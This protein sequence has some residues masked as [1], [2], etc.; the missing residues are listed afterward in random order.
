MPS[1]ALGAWQIRKPRMLIAACRRQL[2]LAQLVPRL[3]LLGADSSSASSQTYRHL[4]SMVTTAEVEKVAAKPAW[5][6][7]IDNISPNLVTAQYAGKGIME[8]LMRFMYICMHLA[9]HAKVSLRA[10]NTS[11]AVDS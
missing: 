6:I 7:T 9:K 11:P 1:A 3:E 8:T 4:H 2:R 10:N 5:P